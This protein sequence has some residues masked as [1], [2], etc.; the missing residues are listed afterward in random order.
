MAVAAHVAVPFWP[1][2]LTLQTLALMLLG[3]F[4]GPAVAVAALLVYVAEGLAGLP[5]FAHGSGPAVLVGPT[6][7]YLIGYVLAAAIPVYAAR[8]KRGI[9]GALAAGAVFLAA[10]AVIFFCGVAWLSTLVGVEKAV[11]GGLVP[12]LAG[13]ALKIA[14]ATAA[15][16]LRAAPRA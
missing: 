7:G 10:D 16:Q 2:P 15:V 12:F 4:A 3:A 13:E 14:I 9:T 6:G 11:A 8:M 5:V 1:V